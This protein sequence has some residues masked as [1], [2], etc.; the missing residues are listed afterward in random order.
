M[1]VSAFHN[2]G[3]KPWEIEKLYDYDADITSN[4]LEVHNASKKE[5]L[6]NQGFYAFK[7]TYH[8]RDKKGFD[9]ADFVGDDIVQELKEQNRKGTLEARDKAFA[10]YGK[11]D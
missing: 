7:I 10:K 4:I 11:D 2:A 1:L 8:M 6:F 5:E 3:Y 9:L